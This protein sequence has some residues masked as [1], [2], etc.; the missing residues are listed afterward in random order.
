MS[1]FGGQRFFLEDKQTTCPLLGNAT[2]CPLLITAAGRIWYVSVVMF[3]W[4]SAGLASVLP[5]E[6]GKRGRKTLWDHGRSRVWYK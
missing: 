6:V 3:V 2:T 5:F 4:S 1:V